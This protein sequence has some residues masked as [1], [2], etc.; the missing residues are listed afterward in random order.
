MDGTEVKFSDQ[1]H[2]VRGMS[3][4]HDYRLFLFICNSGLLLSGLLP[5]PLQDCC[6]NIQARKEG[7][8]G[9]GWNWHLGCG[10]CWAQ[11]RENP[12]A[13]NNFSPGGLA[14]MPEFPHLEHWGFY[15]AR[16]SHYL[17]SP[18]PLPRGHTS[19]DCQCLREQAA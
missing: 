6:K 14:Q 10:Y 7:R 19:N 13:F 8:A 11:P 9:P 17:L 15:F 16:P 18:V 4:F 3:P 1:G 2:S 12:A 5:L